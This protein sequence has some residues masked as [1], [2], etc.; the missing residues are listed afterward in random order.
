[1]MRLNNTTETPP[2]GYRYW[3]PET[4]RWIPDRQ[5]RSGNFLSLQDLLAAL[6]KHYAAN[7]LNAPANLADLIQ[8]QMC[9]NLPVGW[10]MHFPAEREPFEPK[11]PRR[12]TRHLTLAGV[13]QGTQTLISWQVAGRPKVETGE[14]VR[15][16]EVCLRCPENLSVQGCSGCN[17][18]LT[19]LVKSFVGM[20]NLPQISG[21]GSCSVCGCALSAKIWLP[22]DILKSHMDEKQLSEFPEWC[23]LQSQT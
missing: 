5:E 1:M 10:C 18:P 23:W 7:N 14:A 8:H 12:Q 6:K 4:Q 11:G 22:L 17:N 2:G 15:R 20:Q 9:A 19:A 16:A 21:L 13:L 3:V